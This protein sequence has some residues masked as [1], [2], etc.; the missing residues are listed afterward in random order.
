MTD[1]CKIS[2][3]AKDLEVTDKTIYNWIADGKLKMMRPGFVSQLDA[4]EVW[5]QQR[6]DKSIFSQEMARKGIIRD[7]IG[8]FRTKSEQG[9]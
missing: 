1:W 9:E 2:L 3:I 7:S 8:R 4:Y 5:I 6:V